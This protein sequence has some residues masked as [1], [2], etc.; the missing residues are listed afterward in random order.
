M[1]IS[2]L[3]IFPLCFKGQRAVVVIEGRVGREEF[4]KYLKKHS[5]FAG[6]WTQV[7]THRTLSLSL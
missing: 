6:A 7:A 2:S 5:H 4:I 1:T 3:Q